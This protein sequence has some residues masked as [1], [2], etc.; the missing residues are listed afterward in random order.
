MKETADRET[1]EEILDLLDGMG[2]RYWIDG[3]WGVDIILGRQSR[4]HRDIDVDF[5]GE[6]TDVLL[7]AL[8]DKGYVITTDW[9]PCRIELSH[10]LL[11]YIDIHPFVIAEDGSARQADPEGGWYDLQAEWF[12]SAV[13]EGRK[14]PCISAGAQ[15]PFHTGYEPREVDKVDMQNLDAFLKGQDKL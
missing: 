8:E 2:M 3:G 6:Y 11:G 15:K 7:K 4:E 5:D 1:L 14:I 10:P 13:F 12:S 9:R